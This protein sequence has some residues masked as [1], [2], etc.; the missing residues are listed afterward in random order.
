MTRV[1]NCSS[2][3][4]TLD[5]KGKKREINKGKGTEEVKYDIRM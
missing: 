3:Q 4:L 1:G 5:Q 2:V